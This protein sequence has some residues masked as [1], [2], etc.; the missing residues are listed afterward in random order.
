MLCDYLKCAAEMMAISSIDLKDVEYL[1]S[2]RNI[3][4]E[5]ERKEFNAYAEE[6]ANAYEA[7]MSLNEGC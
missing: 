5:Q 7:M 1:C 4:F 3:N 6:F 2:I